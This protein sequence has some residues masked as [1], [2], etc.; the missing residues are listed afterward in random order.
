MCGDIYCISSH[1]G[2]INGEK[3]NRSHKINDGI[4]L[5]AINIELI[6]KS[7]GQNVIAEGGLEKEREEEM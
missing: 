3:G 2:K 7:M 5:K 1:N 6:F 4:D